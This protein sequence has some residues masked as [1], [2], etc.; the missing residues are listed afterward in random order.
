MELKEV[1][2]LYNIDNKKR[3]QLY[4]KFFSSHQV[5]LK[6]VTSADSSVPLGFLAYGSEEQKADYDK[7]GSFPSEPMMVFSGFTNQRLSLMLDGLRSQGL[8]EVSLK[9][10]L[11]EHNAVWDSATLYEQLVEERAQFARNN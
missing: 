8:T 1:V 11:T 7:S 2:L 10:V 5:E 4:E 6:E 3:Y 9:A